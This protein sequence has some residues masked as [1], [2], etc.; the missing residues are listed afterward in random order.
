MRSPDKGSTSTGGTSDIVLVD[1]GREMFE[2]NTDLGGE[3][4]GLISIAR[5]Q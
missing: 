1:G 2:I 4:E 3:V 5:R